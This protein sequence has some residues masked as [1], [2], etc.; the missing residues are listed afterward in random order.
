MSW[1]ARSSLRSRSVQQ[2]CEASGRRLGLT[3]HGQCVLDHAAGAVELALG[4]LGGLARGLGFGTDLLELGVGR[5]A[6]AQRKQRAAGQQGQR[7][8][9]DACIHGLF[10]APVLGGERQ[11]KT[12]DAAL[13]HVIM[14]HRA[15][16]YKGKWRPLE[17]ARAFFVFA[18]K[19]FSIDHGLISCLAL[20]MGSASLPERTQADSV[21]SP[22]R[23]Q[24]QAPG[25]SLSRGL[26]ICLSV[27]LP[28][29]N[30]SIRSSSPT[31]RQA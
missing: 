3:R 31:E 1:S 4:L 11:W 24:P 5:A 27:G 20:G 15:G 26:F 28:D 7:C 2:F 17:S 29:R 18:T 19:L 25:S 6:S 9:A 8:F 12:A 22:N 16:R 21:S 10:R 14:K 13:P 23:I 30:P